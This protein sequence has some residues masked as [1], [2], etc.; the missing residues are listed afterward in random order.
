MSLW[1]KF[2]A[3][4][5]LGEA[6]AIDAPKPT[7][8]DAEFE[9]AH[10][11]VSALLDGE[12]VVV[13]GAAKQDA[14]KPP[15]ELE[16]LAKTGQ[17]DGPT[18]DEALSILRR[19]RGTQDETAAL[20]AAL[21]VEHPPSVLR[22]ASAE[23]LA[24]RGEEERAIE[25]LQGDSSTEGLLLS[26][27]LHANRGDLPR[28]IGAIE[29]VLARKIDAPGARER[30]L[31]WS[32]SLGVASRQRAKVDEATVLN[33][34]AVEGPFRILREVARGG[35]GT[36]YEAADDVLGRRVAFKVYHGQGA[37]RAVVEREVKVIERFRGPGVARVFDASLDDGWIAL[38]WVPRGSLRDLLRTGNVE[39][40]L[41]ISGWAFPLA[42]ALARVHREGWVHAD[43]KPA[44]VLLRASDDAILTDFGI[45]RTAGES[46]SGGSP[47]YL[48]PERLGG[49]KA[50]PLDDI[51]GFG[52]I[53]EDV[54]QALETRGVG[55]PAGSEMWTRLVRI[56][57]GPPSHRPMDGA[58]LE[59]MLRR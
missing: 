5:G 47:G 6:P 58:Q 10:K 15:T 39:A 20:A 35:A 3:S 50:S 40:L 57:L 12:P 22:V 48:S 30:H 28:A 46:S 52:R 9:A 18:A 11:E 16:A 33:A 14:R 36:V 59:A 1:Q 7:A 31:R 49:E 24:E 26:A 17:A 41:P 19:L 27:D 44:N 37:D 13:L 38:E 51:Y 45:S 56:C 21:A 34:K 54:L 42:R 23:M 8:E 25:V 2:K 32:R 43:I 55:D 53:I 29:R 4:V